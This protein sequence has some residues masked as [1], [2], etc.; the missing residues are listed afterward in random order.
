MERD[1]IVT[2]K[3]YER[4]RKLIAEER[5]FG[6]T[7]DPLELRDLEQELDRAVIARAEDIPSNIITMNTQFALEDLDSGDETIYSLVYPEYADFLENRISIIAPIGTAML[8]YRE[9]DEIQ[10][11]IPTGI[12]RLKIKRVMYQPEAAGNFEL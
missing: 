10:W 6:R 4:L 12:A 7:F 8:G 11:N 9:G 2:A 1:I 3:D 5:E